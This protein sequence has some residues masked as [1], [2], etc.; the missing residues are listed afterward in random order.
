MTHIRYS[1]AWVND[2]YDLR[3]I[4]DRVISDVFLV[5][6]IREDVILRHLRCVHLADI[7]GVVIGF[8]DHALLR[9]LLLLSLVLLLSPFLYQIL[10]EL[11]LV[12]LDPLRRLILRWPRNVLFDNV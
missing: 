1:P 11:R 2:T 10:I 3:L 9:E 12:I 6:P 5:R 4:L 8:L 7:L